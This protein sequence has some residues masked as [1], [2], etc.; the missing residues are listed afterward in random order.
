M[1]NSV[2]M[3]TDFL[4]TRFRATSGSSST[5]ATAGQPD[6]SDS[7]VNSVHDFFEVRP[8]STEMIERWLTEQALLE[9]VDVSQLMKAI[10]SGVAF[11]SY[12][13][14]VV[15]LYIEYPKSGDRDPVLESSFITF[16]GAPI[17]SVIPQHARLALWQ[18]LR[19]L[20]LSIGRSGSIDD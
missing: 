6:S 5:L 3:F 18:A 2:A 17:A 1:A 10:P 8:W 15:Q 14:K 12:G 11:A 16:F 13:Q 9:H 7:S 20:P 4:C 19:S